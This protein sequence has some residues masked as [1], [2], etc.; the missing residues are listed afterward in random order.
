VT[1]RGTDFVMFEVSDLAEAARFYRDVLGLPQEVFSEEYQWAEFNCGNVTLALKGGAAPTAVA[2]GA[3]LALA[4]ADLQATYEELKT[5]GVPPAGPPRDHG[6]CRHLE[7]RD[8]DGHVVILHRR[9]DGTF[10][11]SPRPGPSDAIP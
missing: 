9:A 10:G 1:I 3:R 6:C 2:A 5:K 7:V 4:V 11:Q 8:P